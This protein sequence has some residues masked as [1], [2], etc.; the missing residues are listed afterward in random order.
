[1]VSPL[2]APLPLRGHSR[3]LVGPLPAGQ[4]WLW[5]GKLLLSLDCPR[6]TPGE[7]LHT[8]RGVASKLTGV[9]VGVLCA[10]FLACF[11]H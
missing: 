1:M 7:S 4:A 2:P 11:A 9:S 6:L 8:L 3:S 10:W 5:P